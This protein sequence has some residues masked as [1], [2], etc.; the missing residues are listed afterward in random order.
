MRSLSNENVDTG[1]T[2][3]HVDLSLGDDNTRALAVHAE[4]QLNDFEIVEQPPPEDQTLGIVYIGNDFRIRPIPGGAALDCR[5]A[6]I[7]TE[8]ITYP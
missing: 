6:G 2:A 8:I 1:Q 5:E 3:L 4:P 7:W